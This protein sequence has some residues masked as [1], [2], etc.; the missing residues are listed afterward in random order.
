MNNRI[1]IELPEEILES[2]NLDEE[3]P[4]ESYVKDGKI[5]IN[6]LDDEDLEDIDFDDVI[7][8]KCSGCPYYCRPCGVCTLDD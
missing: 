6:T 7:D 5:I 2:L 4:I 3:T 1:E 8:E